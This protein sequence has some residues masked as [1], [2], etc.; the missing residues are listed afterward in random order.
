MRIDGQTRACV[1]FHLATRCPRSNNAMHLFRTRPGHL[2]NRPASDTYRRRSVVIQLDKLLA[3]IRW[4]RRSGIGIRQNL[5]QVDRTAEVAGRG[6]RKRYRFRI[7][8][9]AFGRRSELRLPRHESK[10]YFACIVRQS[11]GRAGGDSESPRARRGTRRKKRIERSLIHRTRSLL[12]HNFK[13]VIESPRAHTRL[14]SQ[15]IVRS[16]G[17]SVGRRKLCD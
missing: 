17:A 16:N 7:R 9:T 14:R 11:D 5:I 13:P 8:K 3:C 10:I 12:D 15:A 4:R 6:Q 2:G 1:R